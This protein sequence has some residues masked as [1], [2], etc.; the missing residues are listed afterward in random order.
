MIR[1]ILVAGLFALILARSSEAQNATG[2]ETFVRIRGIQH[3]IKLDT[4][5]IWNEVLATP[6]AA[7]SSARRIL[8]SLKLR[9][10]VADSVRGVLHSDFHVPSRTPAG[11]QRSWTVRCGSGLTGDHADTW[12]LALAYVVYIQPSKDG[13]TR[14]GTA[15]FGRADPI[16]G[17]STGS[18]P[19]PS[20][21][22]MEE[23][24]FKAIQLR[25]L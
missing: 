10:Q 5:V 3:P 20:T 23:L 13:M 11:R 12:R 9:I 6:A 25:V 7:Y 22:K 19:C 14:V 15:F 1:T 24:L 21:G 4:V 17:V 18:M 8:D 16:Q 2:V